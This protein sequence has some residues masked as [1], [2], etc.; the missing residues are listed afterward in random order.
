MHT[1]NKASKPHVA[2]NYKEATDIKNPHRPEYL[3]AIADEYESH[4]EMGT[5]IVVDM[6]D[7]PSGTSILPS[8]W[9]FDIKD[10]WYGLRFKARWVA[11]GHRQQS[12]QWQESYCP[13]VD[14]KAL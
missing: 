13:G 3:R 1:A 8:S 12:H 2:R 5:Y 9:V 6:T 7:V 4:Q 11:G 14:W 10:E